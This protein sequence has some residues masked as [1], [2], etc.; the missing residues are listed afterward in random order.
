MSYDGKTPTQTVNND[1]TPTVANRCSCGGELI[2]VA[3][4]ENFPMTRAEKDLQFHCLMARDGSKF[5]CMDQ[6]ETW[7]R[8][9]DVD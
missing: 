2:Y 7:A 3:S 9:A 8:L 4:D 6:R 5:F 1:V